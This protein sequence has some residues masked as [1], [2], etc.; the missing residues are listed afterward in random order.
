MGNKWYGNMS[1]NRPQIFGFVIFNIIKFVLLPVAITGCIGDTSISD[2]L[3]R[4][5]ESFSSVSTVSVVNATDESDWLFGRENKSWLVHIHREELSS[6]I[7]QLTLLPDAK[8]SFGVQ[9]WVRYSSE[10]FSLAEESRTVAVYEKQIENRNSKKLYHLRCIQFR[11]NK[12]NDLVF[13]N[14][15]SF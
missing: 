6:F 13:I 4:Y 7:N 3:K 14:I 15:E 10:L 5:L 11:S 12:T 1:V 2:E 9:Y 8:P